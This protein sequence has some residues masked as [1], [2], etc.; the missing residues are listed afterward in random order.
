MAIVIYLFATT[1]SFYLF[2]LYSIILG[3][4][5]KGTVPVFQTMVAESLEKERYLEKAYGLSSFLMSTM[6]V[7]A[8]IILGYISDLFGITA[9]FYLCAG[10]A[11]TATVPAYFFGRVRQD[12]LL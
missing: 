1:N 4:L 10:F 2:V 8:P 11:L 5:T 12:K 9:A 6:N 7:I 3:A